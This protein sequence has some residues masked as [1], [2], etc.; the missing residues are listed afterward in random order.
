MNATFYRKFAFNGIAKNK[1]I[2]IPFILSASVMVLVQYLIC[3]LVSDKE[4]KSLKGGDSLQQI[5]AM[6]IPVV[7]IFATILLFYTS[8]FL[9]RRRKKEFGLY[10]ILGMSK[11]NLAKVLLFETAITSG[12]SIGGGLF[13]GIAFSK[14]I[15][16]I[17]LNV[18]GTKGGFS[19]NIVPSSILLTLIVFVIIFLLIFFNSLR[20][21]HMTSP[22]ELL[23]SEAAGEKP[24]KANPVF[25]ILGAILLGVGYYIAATI[26]EPIE[27]LVF[28]FVAVILVI[29]GT[30]LLFVS[31]SV[32][33]CKL[34]KRNSRYYYNK[35]HFVS[36]SSM[37][38]RMK[39]NGAGLATICILS[40]AVL[41]MLS[42]TVCLIAGGED[43]F[44]KRYPREI[45]IDTSSNKPEDINKLKQIANDTAIQCGS[46]P[47]NQLEYSYSNI[48]ARL[49][50]NNAVIHNENNLSLSNGSIMGLLIISL[51]DYNR[52][53]NTNETL[54]K[55]E[56]LLGS[57]M[58][59]YNHSNILLEGRVELRIKKQIEKL[60]P[61][62]VAAMQTFPVL[63]LVV[64][65]IDGLIA[66]ITSG[67]V[68]SSQII[69]SYFYGFDTEGDSTARLSFFDS[70]FEKL[71]SIISDSESGFSDITFLFESREE[72][73]AS[74][75]SLYNGLFFLAI[76][77]GVVCVGAA[78]L[79]MYYK[80]ITEGFEDKSRFAIM[81]KVGM[82]KKEISKSVNSQMLTVFFA[83]LIGAGI[84]M[85]AAFHIIWILL[86]VFGLTNSMTLILITLGCY[87]V[88][89]ILYT[90]VYFMT[91]RSYYKIVSK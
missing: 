5:L 49:N 11:Q 72:E 52:I 83:P 82:T 28:F 88:F 50:G 20:Q 61:N 55:D 10:N 21:I 62:G 69:K 70:Y 27:A 26:V 60:T 63:H 4:I 45:V 17:M 85:L 58:L 3:F 37:A 42:S 81:Q 75:F 47:R 23:K 36:I 15:Q 86:T 59:D 66:E 74:Y 57:S 80:Q 44:A 34:L 68:N 16:L 39:R 14:L 73:R 64:N 71:N 12:I 78:V 13:A 9:I 30:L 7:A 46:T 32:F 22:V 33:V 76:L 29:F 56:V 54:A 8:S 79:I 65:D 89:C 24:P 91:S 51:E 25:A 38:Y 87:L 43:L 77:L 19:L 1:K 35:K 6:G 40:T 18:L 67:Q 2:Y 48:I 31:G 84:H 53:N 90:M 41:V